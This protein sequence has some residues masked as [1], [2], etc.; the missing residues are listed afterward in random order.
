MG[1]ADSEREYLLQ[2]VTTTKSKI[3]VTYLENAYSKVVMFDHNGKVVEE[4]AFPPYSSTAGISGNLEED[5]FF[6]AL[7]HLHSPK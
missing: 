5:E 4:I 1:G 7:I 3:I 2:S 6:M